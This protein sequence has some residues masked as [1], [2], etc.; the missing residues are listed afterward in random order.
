MF[1]WKFMWV[2]EIV[3]TF[4]L[5]IQNLFR[6]CDCDCCVYSSLY[7]IPSHSQTQTLDPVTRWYRP[8][9][10]PRFLRWGANP[11]GR[12]APTN[13]LTKLHENEENST[14]EEGRLRPKCRSATEDVNK[15]LHK[16]YTQTFTKWLVLLSKVFRNHWL[17]TVCNEV[18]AR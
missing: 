16:R 17:I 6:S 3:Q 12:G 2:V 13:Y 1:S 14:R 7:W 4:F 18:A 10:D 5:V 9:G 8:A 15:R 11:K